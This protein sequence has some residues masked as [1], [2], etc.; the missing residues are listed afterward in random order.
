MVAQLREARKEFKQAER[1]ARKR[2]LSSQRALTRANKKTGGMS[3]R[4][5]VH[6]KRRRRRRAAKAAEK[7]PE[8]KYEKLSLEEFREKLSALNS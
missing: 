5:W 4:Q 3:A 6:A 8:L 7:L 2:L 1:D